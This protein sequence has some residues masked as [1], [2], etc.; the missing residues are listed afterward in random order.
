MND[1]DLNMNKHRSK[2]SSNHPKQTIHTDKEIRFAEFEWME[3]EKE[4]DI[5]SKNDTSS[6]RQEQEPEVQELTYVPIDSDWDGLDFLDDMQVEDWNDWDESSGSTF[7]SKKKKK[8]TI[9]SPV[10]DRSID[11]A[12]DIDQVKPLIIPAEDSHK[13]TNSRVISPQTFERDAKWEEQFMFLTREQTFV[14][15]AREFESVTCS[16][17]EYVSYRA[18]WPT[19]EQMSNAQKKWY[20]YWRKEVKLGRYPDTDLSY[21]FIYIYELIHGIGWSTPKDGLAL[22]DEVWFG[23]GE[24]EK[25]LDMY[26]REW[27]FD[28]CLVH[29]LE[30]PYSEPLDK[31]PRKMSDELKEREWLRRFTADKVE[32]TWDLL[33]MLIDYDAEKS[34]FFKEQGRKEMKFYAPKIVA[35]VDRYWMK[36]NGT[37]LIE[38]FRP[39]DVTKKR[40][41]F[42]SAVY[43][44]DFYGR[45]K[46]VKV[47]PI[48]EH[49][50]LRAYL[51]QLVRF[52]ENKLRELSGYKGRLRGVTL[53]PEVEEL[54]SRYLTKE[55]KEQ[56]AVTAKAARP[57]VTINT[58]KLRRLQEES[59]AVRD[60]LMI[61]YENTEVLAEEEPLTMQTEMNFDF[62]ADARDHS[63]IEYSLTDQKS[64]RL[65][66]QTT[67][68]SDDHEQAPVDLFAFQFSN[69][70]P[71]TGA[72]GT[73][74]ATQEIGQSSRVV[75]DTSNMDEEWQELAARLNLYHL[76]ALYA[77]KEN[78]GAAALQA[79][80][81]Q[82]GSMPALLLEEINEAS[83]DLIGDILIDGE[84]I[85]EEYAHELESLRYTEE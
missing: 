79:I 38:R 58:K 20:F 15:Q 9:E 17:A 66:N 12:F 28:F 32:L 8:Q 26:M 71:N 36:K 23:Y 48:S 53:E 24:R 47:T 81:D 25:K 10:Y 44:H 80:A 85:T 18:Y 41:L 40:P 5:P 70:E 65:S 30:V 57:A 67:R 56:E 49:A 21:L 55:I 7:S 16:E 50:P 45:H 43:D 2:L 61:D 42:R 82:A 84:Q 31:L 75:W 78:K 73:N 83:M 11:P 27:I 33:F 62:S 64:E 13:N 29:G 77:L 72:D 37:R 22:L 34:R 76:E 3:E 14:K 74:I 4:V 68:V 52:T 51:T 63:A 60:M 35:L 19:Y 54:I 46:E 1:N 39:E 69:E 59:A 6:H